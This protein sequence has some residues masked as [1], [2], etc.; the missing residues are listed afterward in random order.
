MSVVA[1]LAAA[2]AAVA[3]TNPEYND[4]ALALIENLELWLTQQPHLTEDMAT[5]VGQ[6]HSD[7]AN[8]GHLSHEERTPLYRQAQWLLSEII[9]SQQDGDFASNVFK[10]FDEL[11]DDGLFHILEMMICNFLSRLEDHGP[12]VEHDEHEDA[13][14]DEDVTD[15]EDDTD[16]E[17]EDDA[18]YDPSGEI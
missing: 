11:F 17:Q 1:A 3:A 7:I 9:V 2:E 8:A 15:D 18:G 12:P 5:R 13:V 6:L 10:L 16:D 4:K 14:W